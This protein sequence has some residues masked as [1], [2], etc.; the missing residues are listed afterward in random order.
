VLND[1][2]QLGQQLSR[3]GY[4]IL[5]GL[6]SPEELQAARA[7]LDQAVTSVQRSGESIFTAVIDPNAANVRIY[8]LPA[9]GQIFIDLL[10][11]QCAYRCQAHRPR[12]SLTAANSQEMQS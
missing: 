12:V 7:A 4:C 8:N 9:H 5:P 2:E 11:H 10:Q 3:E 1:S 6:L